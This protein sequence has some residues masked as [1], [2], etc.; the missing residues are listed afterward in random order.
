M[1]LN[2]QNLMSYFLAC[3]FL[4]KNLITMKRNALLN[5]LMIWL[6]ILLIASFLSQANAANSSAPAIKETRNVGSFKSLEVSGAF[7]VYLV[8][9]SQE[10]VIIEADDDLIDRIVTKVSGDELEIYVK[11]T[12]RSFKK[13]KAYIT[14]R[15]LS[16]IEI[17][18]AVQLAGGNAMQ[19]DRLD[20][21]LSGA[22]DVQLDMEANK[23]NLDL[24]G[25]SKLELNGT[26]DQIDAD[27]S[28]ASKIYLEGL[29][30]RSVYFESSG[31]S[32]AVLWVTDYLNIEGSGASTIRYKGEPKTLNVESSGATTVKKI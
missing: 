17:S 14:F 4:M 6:G 9:G 11:G 32:T 2:L 8:Q 15:E 24:S 29:K 23:L 18:G 22:C 26:V 21:D 1:R 27:C 16:E 3:T 25:A 31:A 19:F 5:S 28:G 12:V 13:M 7:E 10:E 20:L 30:A